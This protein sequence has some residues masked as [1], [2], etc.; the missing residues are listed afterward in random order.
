MAQAL[1]LQLLAFKGMNRRLPASALRP[2][3]TGVLTPRELLN[4]R[5]ELLPLLVPRP[6]LRFIDETNN[7]DFPF[8]RTP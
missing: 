8:G 2:S 5:P 1:R 4:F 7:T 3:E 6:A